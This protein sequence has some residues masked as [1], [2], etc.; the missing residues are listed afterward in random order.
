MGEPWAIRGR[1]KVHS[2]T[3]N[4]WMAHEG[5]MG[6]PWA[7]HRRPIGDRWATLRKLM[8]GPMV[9]HHGKAIDDRWA[10]HGTVL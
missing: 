2:L 4:P 10:T 3:I 5:A 6:D 7:T 1:L 9:A 8:D